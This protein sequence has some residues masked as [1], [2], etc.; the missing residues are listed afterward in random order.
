MQIRRYVLIAF[1]LAAVAPQAWAQFSEYTAPGSLALVPIPTRE[2]V[3]SAMAAA[4]WRLGP[5]RAA[6]WVAL[7][8]LT[9]VD[10][11]Y[12][13]ASGRKSDITATLTAGLH[14]YLP[15]GE[16]FILGAYALP[17]YVWWRDLT[18]RRVWNGRY[19]LGAFGYFRRLTLEVKAGSARE[20]QVASDELEQPVTL[21][22]EDISATAE[23][24]VLER[25]GVFGEAT[26][27]KLRYSDR[28]VVLPGEHRLSA[29]DHDETTVGGGIRYRPRSGLTI[30]L[31]VDRVTTDFAP[32]AVNRSSSGT[33][34]FVELGVEG[35]RLDV[36]A[37]VARISLEPG[38]GSSF[39]PLKDTTGNASLGLKIRHQTLEFYGGRSLAYSL[40][41]AQPGYVDRRTGV[42]LSGD[43]GW[44]GSYRL[45]GERGRDDY[46]D[47]D[48][49][50]VFSDD[51]RAWGLLFDITLLRGS[52]LTLGGERTSYTSALPGRG[53]TVNRIIAALHFGQRGATWW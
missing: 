37:R 19:G 1:V 27:A 6:P 17:E 12:G 18:N 41:V 3:E 5:V 16:K 10:N 15:L 48:G 22:H 7:H 49:R 47:P 9:Y 50:S 4:P 20:Q 35:S 43:L 32:S 38:A 52:A 11:V 2:L 13:V 29:L 42:G 34:P 21:R 39:P 51:I 53:R 30:G 26:K 23:L 25:L 36:H 24:H 33:G 14:A 45:Y 46:L 44:R 28:G 8:D 40:L 31:G